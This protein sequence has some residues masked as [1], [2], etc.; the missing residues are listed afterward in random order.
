MEAKEPKRKYCEDLVK[1]YLEI[2]NPNKDEMWKSIKDAILR[3]KRM[4]KAGV[5]EVVD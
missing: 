1:E 4:K 2:E 3:E 5:D